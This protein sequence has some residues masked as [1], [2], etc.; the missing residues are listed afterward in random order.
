MPSF[1]R[2]KS[3]LTSGDHKGD[4]KSKSIPLRLTFME[5]PQPDDYV[6]RN[7]DDLYSKTVRVWKGG[8]W[9]D[10]VM[11][12]ATGVS[13]ESSHHV[14]EGGA[15]SRK[16]FRDGIFGFCLEWVYVNHEGKSHRV[17][18]MNSFSV[19]SPQCTDHPKAVFKDGPNRVYDLMNWGKTVTWDMIKDANAEKVPLTD[20]QLKTRALDEL[21][22]IEARIS[23]TSQSGNNVKELVSMYSA[24]QKAISNR[25][26]LLWD[27]SNASDAISPIPVSGA[28]Y[29]SRKTASNSAPGNAALDDKAKRNPND[30]KNKGKTKYTRGL[31]QNLEG[32]EE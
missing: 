22:N 30:K 28:I 29:S 27:R 15:K 24:L 21:K 9:N 6:I 2:T 19:K 17:R 16:A 26:Y 20:T 7:L 4:K 5:Q 1:N 18:C 10:N 23:E 8:D 3:K 31:T 13:F 25:E 11:N 32:I 12:G 14:P